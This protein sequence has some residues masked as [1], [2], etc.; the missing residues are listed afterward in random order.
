MNRLFKV[1]M[2]LLSILIIVSLFALSQNMCM[3]VIIT[4]LTILTNLI[5]II[6]KHSKKIEKDDYMFV[7]LFIGFIVLVA[8]YH[9]LTIEYLITEINIVYIIQLVYLPWII[10]LIYYNVFFLIK[11]KKINK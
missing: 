7:W 1:I 11:S 9:V 8:L 5:I 6:N 3:A 10:C 4:V 2:L